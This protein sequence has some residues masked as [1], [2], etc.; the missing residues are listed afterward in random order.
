M[1]IKRSIEPAI[2]EFVDNKI[3]LLSGPRQVG[4]TFLAKNIEKKYQY[5]NFDLSE[6]R[7]TIQEKSWL[8]NGELIIFDEIHKMKKWKQWI[9]G[10]YDTEE[11]LNKYI[12]TGSAK[13]D[14]LKKV[15]DSLAGR[16]YSIR[17]NPLSLKEVIGTSTNKNH[18]KKIAQDMIELGSFPEPFLSGSGRKASLW[19]KSHLDIIIRQDLIQTELVKDI[20]SIELLVEALRTRVGHQIVYQNLALELQV[21]PHTIKRWLDILES[22]FIIFRVY[23]F[24]KNILDAVKKEPKI[25]FYD[26]GQVRSD[27]GFKIENL[28]ALHLLKRNQFLDDTEGTDSRLHYI[29][30]K[31]KREIDFVISS[32]SKLSH[33]IE[34]KSSDD[35]FNPH[36]DYFSKRLKPYK[37]I[38]LTFNLKREKDFEYF[39]IRDLAQFLL[40][41][42]T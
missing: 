17:L 13:M 16:N 26:I 8:R 23:P 38:Q 29:R 37:A 41:L 40:E 25:Y 14:A 15:G 12:L 6:H 31:K 21:S 30:D 7:Q 24:T 20:L 34:V 28:V 19:R 9:K 2:S 18:A 32:N 35:N 3:I 11:H 36:L 39:A 1:F 22:L 33:L 5:F 27:M 42:E 4:K 10:I